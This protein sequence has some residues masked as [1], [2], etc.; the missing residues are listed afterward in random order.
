MFLAQNIL[1][2]TQRIKQQGTRVQDVLEKQ[3]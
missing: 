3:D 2:A 1:F